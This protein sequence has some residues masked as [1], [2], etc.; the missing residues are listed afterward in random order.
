MYGSIQGQH[1]LRLEINWQYYF[2]NKHTP[3]SV[4]KDQKKN[5]NC[6]LIFSIPTNQK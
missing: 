3:Y 2:S 5:Q 6:P 4:C 1:Y